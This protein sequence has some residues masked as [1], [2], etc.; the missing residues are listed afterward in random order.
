MDLGGYL[1]RIG[2]DGR[3]IADRATLE[4]LHRLHLRAIPYENLDVLLGRPITTDPR[5]AYDKIVRHRRGG[6]CYEMNGLF[7]WALA[8]I[9]FS[10]TRL[11]SGAMRSQMAEALGN[12]LVLRVDLEGG[13]VLA[14]VGLGCGCLSPLTVVEG[15]FQRDGLDYRLEALEGGWWRFHNHPGRPPPDFDF[16]L[17]NRDEALLSATCLR[18]QTEPDSTFV[19]NLLCFRFTPDGRRQLLGRVLRRADSCGETERRIDSADDLVQVLTE[20]FGI[21]EPEAIGLWPRIVA[22]D[23]EIERAKMD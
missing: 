19:Q 6:W 9:G 10:V 5:A 7:G 16:H 3:P 14:D 11:A 12:H 23:E 1:E 4:A 13:P 17:D 15:P 21:E 18:L 8:E 22:R 20:D 2:F